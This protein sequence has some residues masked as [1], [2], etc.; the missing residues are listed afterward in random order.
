[1]LVPFEILSRIWHFPSILW[2]FRSGW[3]GDGSREELGRGCLE[4][5]DLSSGFTGL[6]GEL[7][8]MLRCV[9]EVSDEK[10][11]V[12]ECPGGPVVRT[13][14]FHCRGPGFNLRSGN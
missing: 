6:R 11:V 9:L 5:K 14:R 3:G 1:M 2:G 12:G 13:P 10:E 8:W 4:P 7:S